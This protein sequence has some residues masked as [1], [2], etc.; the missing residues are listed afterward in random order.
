MLLADLALAQALPA[1]PDY[2]GNCQSPAWSPD[3][4][5]LSWEVNYHDRKIIELFVGPYGAAPTKVV[6]VAR[7]QSAMT[8][9][10]DKSNVEM[11]VHELS[12]APASVGRFVYSASGT[13]RDYDLY[14]EGAGPLAAAPG[15]DG[16]AR[17]SPDGKHIVFT[18]ARTGQGD[19]YLIDVADVGKAPLKLTGEAT[20]SELY[21]AWSPDGRRV[22]FV[23]HTSKGDNLYLIDNIDFPSPRPITAWEHTQ[24]RPTFSPDG[25]M[26]A[27]YS[28]HTVPERFDL[29]VAPLGG[30]PTLVATDVLLN[31]RGPS[32]APESRH[33]IYVKRDENRF[34]PVMVAP[35]RQPSQARELGTGTVGNG[36]L[37]VV[38]R[39]DGKL[40]VAVAAQGRPGDKVR[41]FKRIY[42]LA[43]GPL[44]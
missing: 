30:T 36:D 21:A 42:A 14:I 41:D 11:A 18:S 10:F 39:A 24:T 19:L 12:F 28:D 34:D 43:V 33:V 22:V 38:K 17:W 23:G 13:A 2:E 8:D 1:S 37:D 31:A 9:G 20:S 35:V 3:G 26:V 29:Y 5:R 7:G 16:G 4:A 44:P 6:P 27:F 25:T 40:W 15:A 32:W